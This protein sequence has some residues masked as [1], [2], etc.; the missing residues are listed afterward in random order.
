MYQECNRFEFLWLHCEESLFVQKK[1]GTDLIEHQDIYV[2]LFD[3]FFGSY[4]SQL[5]NSFCA[6]TGNVATSIQRVRT[7]VIIG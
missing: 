3:A 5:L 2:L 4:K 6:I 7:R 1:Q